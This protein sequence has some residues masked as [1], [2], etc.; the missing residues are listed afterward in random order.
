MSVSLSSVPLL[1]VSA[2][3]R[4]LKPRLLKSA[5]AP[6]RSR[7][8]WLPAHL[9]VFSA[10]AF[11]LASGPHAL[12]LKLLASFLIG[13]SFAGMTFVAHEALHGA[14]VRSRPL[15]RV[16]G[17]IGFLPFVVS[18]RLWEAWHNQVHHGHT[19]HP[20]IDPDAY[21]T[22]I[23]YRQS[24]GVRA[25]TALAMG[26]RKLLGATSLLIGFSVQS[27]HMLVDGRARGLLKP[28]QHALAVAETLLAIALWVALAWLLGPLAFLFAF[29]LPLLVAN[30]IVMSLILT[31]H[32][33]SPHTDVND[34]LINSL[35][36][37]GPRWFE[38]LTLGFGFHVEHHLFPAMSARHAH[39]V[40][41]LLRQRF[42]DR[43][44]SIP[45]SKALRALHR[46][47]RVYDTP[48]TLVDPKTGRRWQTLTPA[49]HAVTSLPKTAVVSPAVPS[50]M[51]RANVLS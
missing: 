5:F 6:A 37:T 23:E 51:K 4:D 30:V 25:A 44:Q 34:P 46:S 45:L 28:G 43:Y 47:A 1:P 49:T 9:S 39:A 18:P 12:V 10:G 35:S 8:L 50:N 42:S 38:W 15:R 26:G 27:A 21:P 19:N 24:F 14:L 20:G 29:A 41:D 36:V 17:W 16:I 31:N 40:R 48:T 33:L 13:C 32:S 2:Y 7:L 22:L 3:A 11:W